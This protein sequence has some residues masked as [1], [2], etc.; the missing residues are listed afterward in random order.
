M[1]IA[2][3]THNTGFCFRIIMSMDLSRQRASL[4]DQYRTMLHSRTNSNAQFTALLF[5][6]LLLPQHARFTQFF[7]SLLKNSLECQLDWQPEEA[8]K[9]L[10]HLETYALNLYSY[11]WR[12]EFKTIKV[13]FMNNEYCSTYPIFLNVGHLQYC[14]RLP[15]TTLAGS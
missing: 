12:S 13:C 1:N 10:E 15:Q 8:A 14:Q 6:F 5:Q 7:S 2:F 4:R 11:P 3:L 9:A